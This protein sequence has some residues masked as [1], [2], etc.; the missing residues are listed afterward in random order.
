MDQELKTY[1]EG[2]DV[3]AKA[4]FDGQFAAAARLIEDTSASLQREIGEVRGDVGRLRDT[5][6]DVVR[7]LE[8]QAGLMQTGVQK[9][10]AGA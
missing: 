10:P 9:S 4:Y 1:L 2:R 5:L 6:E 8:R 7:R 3:A